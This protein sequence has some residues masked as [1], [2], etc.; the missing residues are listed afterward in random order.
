MIETV[1][2]WK[3]DEDSEE[4]TCEGVLV[5]AVDLEGP[6][7]R[8][9]AVKFPPLLDAIRASALVDD[10]DDVYGRSRERVW[11]GAVA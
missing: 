6:G 1:L 5:R 8:R 4:L 10:P 7:A 9:W 11:V 2:P 3:L